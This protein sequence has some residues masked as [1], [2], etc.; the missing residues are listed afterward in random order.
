[1]RAIIN[2]FTDENAG[3]IFMAP[4]VIVLLIFTVFPFLFTIFLSFSNVSLVGG[5][6]INFEGI[7]NWVRLLHDGRFWNSISNIALF[8]SLGVVLEYILGLSLAMLLRQKIPGREF[9][10]ILF[11][12]PI[13]ITPLAVGY[14]FRML[15]HPSRGVFNN[16]LSSIGLPTINFLGDPDLAMF[17]VI[18]TDVWHWTPLIFLL[19]TAGLQGIPESYLEAAQ[20]DGANSWQR[21][22]Y[23]IFPQLIPTS[24]AAILLRSIEASKFMDKLYILTGGGP[25][26]STETPTLFAYLSGLNNFD[27]AYGATIAMAFFVLVL[28]F[29]ILTFLVITWFGLTKLGRA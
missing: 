18:A 29:F 3:R 26:I 14:M 17:F 7:Q 11:L 2:W 5:L 13:S 20:I 28:V 19:L 27:L 8:V 25:G 21:F 16:I 24:I 23:I 10:R 6:S 1:M 4:A 9:F 12:M 15:Y 22:R